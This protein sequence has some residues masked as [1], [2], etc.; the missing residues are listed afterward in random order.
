MIMN[1]EN[2]QHISIPSSS[3]FNIK[4]ILECGQVFRFKKQPFGYIIY[5]GDKKMVVNCQEHSTIIYC[6]DVNFVKKY[7]DLARDYDKIKEQ[8]SEFD[9]LKKPLERVYGIRILKQ[10]PLEVLISF[11]ISANNNIPRI[12]KTL[13]VICENW[14]DNMG[15]Y[16]A[17]PTLKQLAKI[18]M[19]FFKQAGA[20]YRD[21]YLY[22]T[23][24]MLNSGFD[25]HSLYNLPTEE[26]RAELVKLKGVGRK[27]ADCVL[28]FGFGK[29]DVFPA[30]TWVVRAHSE[31]YQTNLPADKVSIHFQKMFGQNSGIAQ[32]YLY[33]ERM[34][35]KKG[36][37]H[38][39]N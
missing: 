23:I 34:I 7:F 18:P 9:F 3:Q 16:Y 24:R 15:D 14:G 38:D 29:T 20:G 37:N 19:E 36:D 26:A 11:I 31:L 4:H 6:N 13:E 8:L 21:K 33:Y 25:L 32:Q 28:L 17:F 35:R 2:M 10:Q 1:I 39:N 5:A 27:V 30:D 12:K 22:Q